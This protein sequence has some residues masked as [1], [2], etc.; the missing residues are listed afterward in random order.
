[1]LVYLVGQKVDAAVAVA[2][3]ADQPLTFNVS[4]GYTKGSYFWYK[5]KK[6]I[7]LTQLIIK[8]GERSVRERRKEYLM[9]LTVQN[10]PSCSIHVSPVFGCCTCVIARAATYLQYQQ[11]QQ[12]MTKDERTD[13][14]TTPL[15][16]SFSLSPPARM[17]ETFS[18]RS[19]LVIFVTL[20]Q[21]HPVHTELSCLLEK[22]KEEE[23]DEKGKNSKKRV[24][25][26]VDSL[27]VRA[28]LGH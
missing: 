16:L 4:K 11:F 7:R 3:D 27:R 24:R 12:R 20:H 19:Q 25:E 2:I 5:K 8:E 14:R 22:E 13:Q 15:S 6:K 18:S 26:K 9:R 17:Q 23:E 28:A 1:M 10:L 21:V